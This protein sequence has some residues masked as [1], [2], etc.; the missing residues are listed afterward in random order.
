MARELEFAMDAPD[1]RREDRPEDE[2]GGRT[3]EIAIVTG[4]RRHGK[5]G[6]LTVTKR[7]LTFRDGLLVAQ[8]RDYQVRIEAPSPAG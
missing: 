5:G 4:V 7:N 3:V 8:G 1:A 2:G 6:G